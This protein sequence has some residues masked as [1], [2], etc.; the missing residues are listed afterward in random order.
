M[1]GVEDL[2]GRNAQLRRDLRTYP[3]LVDHPGDHRL[4]EDLVRLRIGLQHAHQNAVE[5]AEGL[6]VKD[7]IVKIFALNA[8]AF[9]TE[10]D[11]LMR[12]SEV[13][14]DAAEALFFGGRNELAVLQ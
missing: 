14:L 1:L 6:L 4:T 5:F 13:V 3:Q 10:L 11:G 9:E 8:A 7:R 12:K 2:V